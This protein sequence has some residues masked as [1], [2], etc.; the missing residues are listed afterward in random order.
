[1]AA[2]PAEQFPQMV[3]LRQTFPSDA[4]LDVTAAL[5]RGWHLDVKADSSIAVAVGSRGISRI[6][7]VVRAILARLRRA[8]ARPFIVPAMGSHAG[9]TAEGQAQMLAGYGLSEQALGVPVLPSMEVEI[10]GH[11]EDGVPAHLPVEALRADGILVVN[12]IKPHTDLR[13]PIESGLIK[14]IAVG[15]GKQ[16]GAGAFHV[17]VERF[18]FSR[19]VSQLARVKMAKAPFTGGVALLEDQTHHLSRLEVLRPEEIEPAEPALLQQARALMPRL[20]FDDIDL[21]IVDYLGKNISGAGIDPNVIGRGTAG[22]VSALLQDNP[23]RPFVRRLFVRDITPESRG[24]ATGLGLAD[25]TTSRLVRAMDPV[26]TYTNA[27]T[28]LSV[29]AVK[30]PIHFETD[31]QVLENAL[32]TLALDDPR[33]ARVVRIRDSLS[34]EHLE[35]S[36][37]LLPECRGRPEL[38][39]A[40]PPGPMRFD[41]TGNLLPLTAG[42]SAD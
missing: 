38:V 42:P 31:R 28:S 17:G 25:F 11:T 27:L 23:R 9:A 7:E 29:L 34:L 36:T 3:S 18:G 6:D 35:V 10:V 16:A 8:G 20:P 4:P 30:I 32:A 19:V 14:M 15:L 40:G 41:A 39:G 24:N 1:M 37:A 2:V 26:A 13:G 21:L 5:E 22:Y 33:T 12:R